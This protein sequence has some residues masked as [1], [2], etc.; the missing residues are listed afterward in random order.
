LGLAAAYLKN[1]PLG[2]SPGMS[3]PLD[4]VALANHAQPEALKQKTIPYFEP[5]FNGPQKFCS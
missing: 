5:E 3:L 2:N 1:K 4:V